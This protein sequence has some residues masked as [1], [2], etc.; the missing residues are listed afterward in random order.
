MTK[1]HL[2]LRIEFDGDRWH[3]INGWLDIPGDSIEDCLK[4]WIE[5]GYPLKFESALNNSES[6]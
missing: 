6:R 2:N 1:P 3:L 4:L 5:A